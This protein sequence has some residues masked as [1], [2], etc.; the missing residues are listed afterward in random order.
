MKIAWKQKQ[1]LFTLLISICFP[2]SFFGQPTNSNPIIQNLLQ[3]KKT[4][5]FVSLQKE[6]YLSTLDANFNTC[7]QNLLKC[8]GEVY[9]FIN[10][11][12]RL[13]KAEQ[14]GEEISFTRIDSTTYFGYNIA[15]FA[16]CYKNHIYN[17]GGYG[18]WRMNGQ[19]RVF[20]EKVK[21]W[22]IVKLN[23]EIPLLTGKTEGMVW[24][25]V[26]GKKIY[27][28]YY[29]ERNEAIKSKE[30]EETQFIYDVMVLDLEKEE[31]SQLGSLNNY[32][33]EKLPNFRPMTISP[34]GQ[35]IT[36][37]DKISLLDFK[38]NRILSLDVRKD[39]YQTLI[40]AY[41]GNAFYFKD[42]TLFYGNNDAKRL[43]SVVLHY[44]D[45]MPTNEPIYTELGVTSL[46]KK[47]VSYLFLTIPFALLGISV[48]VI[49]KRKSLTRQ[50]KNFEYNDHDS[51]GEMNKQAV[52]DEKEMQLLQLLIQNT[53]AGNTTSIDEQNRILGLV[54]KS[55]EIQKKQRSDIIIGINRKYSFV[56]KQEE[57]IIQKKRTDFDKRSY[58][59]F[60]DYKRMEELKNFLNSSV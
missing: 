32:L 38:N 15:A 21:Q 39:Y 1:L 19:L 37:G 57:P 42:S 50:P 28:A 14:K 41:F 25:D 3:D 22:D 44:A 18:F 5:S 9:V 40:R 58:E 43:D 59:Y 8:G 54:K 56:T 55:T 4:V 17:L 27:T 47:P 23:R 53:S 10:G 30:L 46:T 26:A 60:I 2:L 20:N 16:F 34:W 12:G 49:K 36:V 52:F 24:Y 7:P 29:I 6:L 13:Y 35:M 31:W 48:V 51:N 45:F 33:R 11:S